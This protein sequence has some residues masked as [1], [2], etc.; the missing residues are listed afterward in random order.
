[1]S[2]KLVWLSSLVVFAASLSCLTRAELERLN[3]EEA[4][5]M[6]KEVEARAF[7]LATIGLNKIDRL[8]ERRARPEL[9]PEQRGLIHDILVGYYRRREF[10]RRFPGMAQEP[11][12]I[13]A[14]TNLRQGNTALL[15]LVG[16]FI[17]HD[18][19]TRV[20]H[21]VGRRYYT[22]PARQLA[23]QMEKLKG[24]VLILDDFAE[25]YRHPFHGISADDY[26]KW[27]IE[28][29]LPDLTVII[30]DDQGLLDK[31]DEVVWSHINYVAGGINNR[32]ETFLH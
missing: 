17:A 14:K 25:F 4:E 18:K 31:L 12:I 11:N 32:C 20:E 6:R 3:P 30:L 15:D 9:S 21:I 13:W 26:L 23:R 27:L 24:S 2:A 22:Y 10:D 19:K 29:P 16:D 7:Q 5:Q 28:E 8:A 1:M